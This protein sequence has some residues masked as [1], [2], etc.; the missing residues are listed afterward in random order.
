MSHE[1]NRREREDL[2]GTESDQEE[3]DINLLTMAKEKR[4][5]YLEVFA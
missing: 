5:Y 2:F 1:S 3:E 4:D